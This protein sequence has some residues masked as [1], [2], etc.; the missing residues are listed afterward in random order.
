MGENEEWMGE[1]EEW[2]EYEIEW[3]V[4]WKLAE[5]SGGSEDEMGMPC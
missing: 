1:N 5:G 2:K 4:N 3:E